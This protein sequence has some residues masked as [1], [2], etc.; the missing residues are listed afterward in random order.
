MVIA[1]A[2]AVGAALAAAIRPAGDATAADHG[3]AP[4]VRDNPQLDVNDVYL[5]PKP[6]DATKLV[7]ILTTG[8]LCGQI[9][10]AR[11]AAKGYSYLLRFDTN[12]DAVKDSEAL[13]TFGKPDALGVQPITM[14]FKSSA[15]KYR[16][17]G[18]TGTAFDLPDGGKCTAGIFDD[19]FFF[20]APAFKSNL[21]F[22][23]P[24]ANFFFGWNTLTIAMELPVSSFPAYTKF[25]VWG[26]TLKGRKQ[27]DREGKPAIATALIP[28]PKKD[29]FNAGQPKDDIANFGADAT[30]T[31]TTKYGNGA[32]AA[33]LVAA[34]LP[35]I[36]YYD[37][38]VALAYP[39][40]RTLQDDGWVDAVV[41]TDRGTW[42]VADSTHGELVE[43]DAHGSRV[44]RF[45]GI[46]R[47]DAAPSALTL[48]RDA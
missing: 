29:A 13:F 41:P 3:D 16:V 30:A 17:K 8:P 19:P 26:V 4:G 15:T 6:G 9:T 38:A 46:P 1:V 21:A 35:D 48:D 44:G 42:V 22:T 34:L 2:G 24:G 36:L 7:L 18:S 27:V 31:I 47:P 14:N 43:I 10:P 33:A 39:N 12:G 37:P 25:G 40:G 11:F 5:F 20:D 28:G 32:N 45:G 23:N